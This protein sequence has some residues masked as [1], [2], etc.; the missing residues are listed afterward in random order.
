MESSWISILLNGNIIGCFECERGVRQGDPLTPLLLYIAEEVFSTSINLLVEQSKAKSIPDPRGLV[1]PSHC[2]Y[3]DDVM[4]FYGG[5]KKSTKAL[6]TLFQRYFMTY[7]Q[8]V[9]PFE[10]QI[11]SGSMC[12]SRIHH[13]FLMLGLK[14]GNLPFFYLDVPIFKGAPK[15]AYFMTLVDKIKMKLENWK[16]SLLSFVGR[17]QLVKSTIHAM[18]IHN[19][20]IYS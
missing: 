19:F 6:I 10:S 16:S 13:I 20:S 1:V 8:F 4:I 5:N 2:L 14:I 12:D 15:A 18:L 3:V 11:F 17:V 9:N 7:G